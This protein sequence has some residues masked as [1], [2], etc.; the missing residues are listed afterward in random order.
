MS[1]FICRTCGVQYEPVDEPPP[2]CTI[3]E[4]PRQYV[5]WEGQRWTDLEELRQ[6]GHRTETRDL[7]PGLSGIGVEPP[8]AIGQR[9]LLVLTR[10]GNLL[11]DPTGFLDDRAV[12]EV[13]RR[14]GL[15]GIAASHP[16]F[17]GVMVEWSRAFDG[18]PIHLPRA[19]RAWITRRDPA[20]R[21]FED[22]V[23]PLPGVTVVRCGGHFP[24]S[25]VLH[26]TEG[27]DGRGALLTGDTIT[28]VQDRRYV[29]FMWSYP[30]LLPLDARSVRRVA[31]AVEPYPFDRIY[32][33]WW[34]RVVAEDAQATLARS[35]ER[36]V[37]RLERGPA[38]P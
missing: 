6:E 28:V 5:G 38:P 20:I 7:E 37:A 10:A 19:D 32:G 1:A 35:V 23:R 11:W 30:N 8:F 14:G 29:S 13:A 16:H 22:V 34:D 25:A 36:Y 24:G 33:G 12:A 9:S 15:A 27:A 4:D 2:H 18:A 3:C 21:L 31:A 26:W 17:Y